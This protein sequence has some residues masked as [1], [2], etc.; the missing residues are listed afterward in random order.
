MRSVRGSG[1]LLSLSLSAFGGAV[2]AQDFWAR[3]FLLDAYAGSQRSAVAAGLRQGGYE[4]SG[5]GEVRFR[6]WYTPRLPDVTVL[7]LT[8]LSPEFGVIWGASSGERAAK[9]RIDPA[10]HLGFVWR[11]A[12]SDGAEVSVSA[13]YPLFGRMREFPC[14]ADYGALGGIQTVNCRLAA[15]PIPP[16]ETLDHM[17]ALGG[18]TDARIVV[19]FTWAF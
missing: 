1:V 15:E 6:D 2:S 5:G 7:F 10:L 8:Q 3:T 4:L 9:Y 11:Q 14:L 18:E 16:E 13:V 12:I 17:V 19:G